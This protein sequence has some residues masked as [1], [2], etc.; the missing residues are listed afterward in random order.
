MAN[1]ERKLRA[2]PKQQQALT[3]RLAG[4]Q[5]E[6]I[7]SQLGYKDRSGAF[8][9][10]QAALKSTLREPAEALRELEAQRLDAANLAIWSPVQQG[11]LQAIDRF[12]KISQRRAD[13]LGLDAP[14]AENTIPLG[15][16]TIHIK[17][18]EDEG[19]HKRPA[20]RSVTIGPAASKGH[21]KA[22][23]ASN[24]KGRI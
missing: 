5:Y 3:M 23:A 7:A 10:V 6:T 15:D 16:V 4:A 20:P 1:A 13:L 24:K 11:N 17:Y 19:D 2:M 18:D 8:R 9:A 21:R 22:N 12:I 14:P